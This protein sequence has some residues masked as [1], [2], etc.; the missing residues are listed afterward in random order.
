VVAD[1]GL[2]EAERRDEL[3][4]ADGFV[5][6]RKQVDDPDPR[7]VGQRLEERRRRLRLIVGQARGVQRAA[8]RNHVE[9]LHI[10]AYRIDLYRYVKPDVC[11]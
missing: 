6:C 9:L 4:G 10:D 8:T 11:V 5:T 3:A 7:G 2:G 1:R